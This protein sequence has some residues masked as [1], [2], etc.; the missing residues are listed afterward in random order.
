M[1]YSD[2]K[3]YENNSYDSKSAARS[4][5]ESYM[6]TQFGEDD[7]MIMISNRNDSKQTD[8]GLSPLKGM[9]LDLSLA[10]EAKQFRNRTEPEIQEESLTIV[11]DLPDGSQGENVFKL[12]QTVEVLKSYVESEFGIPMMEQTLYLDDKVMLNPFSLLDFPEV[13]GE[14]QSKHV[15]TIAASNQY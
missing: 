14:S 6:N 11:F 13:K 4:Y 9:S 7:N 2:E 8:S 15:F 12:G 10:A 5:D 3:G 1:S